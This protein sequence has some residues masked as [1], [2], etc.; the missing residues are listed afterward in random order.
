MPM[1][2]VVGIDL[3]FVVIIPSLIAATPKREYCMLLTTA[4]LDKNCVV[5]LW[6]FLCASSFVSASTVVCMYLATLLLPLS[7]RKRKPPISNGS[8]VGVI[9]VQSIFCVT[10]YFIYPHFH[11]A[12]H[13]ICSL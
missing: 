10:V 2:A 11:G 13:I 12:Y 7:R 5:R 4:I 3:L 8:S 9:R 1:L 6:A